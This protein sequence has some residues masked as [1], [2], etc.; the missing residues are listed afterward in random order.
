MGGSGR[1]EREEAALG[2]TRS[3]LAGVWEPGRHIPS[4]ASPLHAIPPVRYENSDQM[5]RCPA[6]SS[7]W[8]VRDAIQPSR[9]PLEASQKGKRFPSIGKNTVRAPVCKQPLRVVSSLNEDLRDT[10]DVLD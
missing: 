9:Q 6:A 10:V 5:T 3:I 7:G 1:E 4:R 2:S 8:P